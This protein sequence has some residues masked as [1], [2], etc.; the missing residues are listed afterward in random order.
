VI[1]EGQLAY[2]DLGCTL[3]QD[4]GEWWTSETG[5]LPLPLGVNV[6]RKSFDLRFKRQVA[7]V[8]RASIQYALD[9]RQEAL[10]YAQAFAREI[11]WALMDEF[12]GMYVNDLTLEMT[13]ESNEAIRELFK[14]SANAGLIPA[15][16]NINL[17][18]VKA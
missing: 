9:H 15:V 12:V 3:S 6:V 8:I 4:L 5:G 18:F 17:E 2:P 11:P 16:R 10:E 1:H 14:R 13:A 7:K